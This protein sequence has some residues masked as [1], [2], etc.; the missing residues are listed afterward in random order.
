MDGYILLAVSI[1]E[2]LPEIVLLFHVALADAGPE[3]MAK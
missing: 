2:C 1:L 3:V